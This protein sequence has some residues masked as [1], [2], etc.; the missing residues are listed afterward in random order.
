VTFV[1]WHDNVAGLGVFCIKRHRQFLE[2][3][4]VTEYEVVKAVETRQFGGSQHNITYRAD[5]HGHLA[6]SRKHWKLRHLHIT[7]IT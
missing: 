5:C 7:I 1:N 6:R 4:N 3:K 2:S